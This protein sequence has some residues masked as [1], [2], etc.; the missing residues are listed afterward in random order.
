[1]VASI[2]GPVVN[3]LVAAGLFAVML[4]VV[5]SRRPQLRRRR[6]AIAA[7]SLVPDPAGDHEARVCGESP[8]GR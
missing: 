4:L 5:R 1:M 2:F 8:T 6:S 7:P 3:A